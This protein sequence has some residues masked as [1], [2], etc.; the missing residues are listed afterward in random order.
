MQPKK[1]QADP[2]THEGT[3]L[4]QLLRQPLKLFDATIRPAQREDP[5]DAWF[6]EGG[7]TVWPAVPYRPEVLLRLPRRLCPICG[8]PYCCLSE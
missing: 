3:P 7:A 8:D 6:N 2:A 1:L 4:T 5:K